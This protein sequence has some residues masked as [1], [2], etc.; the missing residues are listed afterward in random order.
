MKGKN[1]G[2]Y[3]RYKIEMKNKEKEQQLRKKYDI[4]YDKKVVIEQSSK[5]DKIIYYL[6]SFILKTSKVA[7]YS[8]VLCLSSIG[9]TVLINESLREIFFELLKIAI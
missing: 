7:L 8:I 6:S 2:F 4:D 1:K 5:L 3:E 9:A